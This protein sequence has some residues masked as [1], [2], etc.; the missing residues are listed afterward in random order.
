MINKWHSLVGCCFQRTIKP[1]THKITPRRKAYLILSKRFFFLSNIGAIA[2]APYVKTFSE[3][4]FFLPTF[5][6]GALKTAN[7]ND[8]RN[9]FQNIA[10][11]KPSI[12]YM[13]VV[14]SESTCLHP[15]SE[16][17]KK[18]LTHW[19]C[20]NSTLRGFYKARALQFDR[21]ST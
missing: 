17:V 3:K 5:I 18:S 10:R 12:P 13:Q 14:F 2:I 15:N 1:N 8:L 7:A 9:L 19:H 21:F 20:E 16:L 4:L 11:L 6:C